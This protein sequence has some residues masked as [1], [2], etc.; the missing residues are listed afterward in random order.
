MVGATDSDGLTKPCAYVVLQAD[1]AF[2]IPSFRTNTK[3]FPVLPHL[4]T[5]IRGPLEVE[6]GVTG[7]DRSLQ[8]A[9]MLPNERNAQLPSIAPQP[10]EYFQVDTLN[11]F[12][13]SSQQDKVGEVTSVGITGFGMVPDLPDWSAGTAFGESTIIPKGISYSTI[14]VTHDLNGHEQIDP[15]STKTTIEVVNLL[16]GKGNDH[17][18]ITSTMVPGPDHP[19][20]N[21][22][23]AIDDEHFPLPA[24]VDPNNTPS[25]HG[26]IT[27]VHGGGN[28]TL[29]VK[30][31]LTVAGSSV[32]RLDH[33]S[34]A[35][36]GFAVGQLVSINGGP[37]FTIAQVNG[38]TLTLSGNPAAQGTLTN[39]TVSVI[40]PKTGTAR[41]GG[42]TIVVTGG[43]STTAA[44]GPTSPLVI[45]GDTSQDGRWYSSSTTNPVA[46]RFDD[47]LPFTIGGGVAIT[48]NQVTSN[49]G[50]VWS[51]GG[52]VDGQQVRIG[53]VFF[54]IVSGS[55]TKTLVLSGAPGVQ[56]QLGN[57]DPTKS[58]DP[59]VLMRRPRRCTSAAPSTMTI[60]SWP[61]APSRVRAYSAGTTTSSATCEISRSSRREQSAK[62][63]TRF[64]S[65]ILASR[66]SM[67]RFLRVTVSVCKGPTR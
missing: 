14:V 18:T 22:G 48:G 50:S 2:T 52:F 37:T 61:E 49:D 57:S 56:G 44:G 39:I 3:P 38:D 60:S 41:V 47:L 1:P 7:A 13:D 19:G 67:C 26:G 4:L 27:T 66:P 63:G 64:S 65:S 25:A 10:P 54:T 9:I 43:A 46:L 15:T 53:G 5:R 36:A 51:L 6:G 29:A 32:Q 8:P 58:P 20:S 11:V 42:D 12:D 28:H 23:S 40:D 55:A 21:S 30:G 45:Y 34:W 17:V 35:D 16:L 24:G 33:A 31:N 59:T 62:S